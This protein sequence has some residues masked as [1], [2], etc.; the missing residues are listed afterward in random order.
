MYI[1]PLIY[2]M[3]LAAS[4]AFAQLTLPRVDLPRLPGVEVPAVVGD[5]LSTASDTLGARR[6]LDLRQLRID[7][8]IAAH[9]NVIEADPNGAPIVRSQ[10]LAF[11]PSEQA[12]AKARAAG[13]NVVRKHPLEGLDAQLVVLEA[14]SGMSTRR[15]LAR[16]RKLD[17]PGV[18]D[19]NHLFEPGASND[20]RQRYVTAAAPQ[21]DAVL[22]SPRAGAGLIDGG[23]DAS[24]P[25]FR[26]V[27]LQQRGCAKEAVPSAHGTAVASLLVGSAPHF[28]GAAAGT[29]L[30]AYDVYCG[31][32]TGGSAD[33]LLD[34][35]SWMAAERVA[36]INVSLV[37]PPNRA[38]ETVVRLLLARG[39]LIV[40][41]VGNDGPAAPP[42][43]PAAYPGVIGVTGVDSRRRVLIEAGRGAH[44][45]FA[46]PGADIVA[47][48]PG[49]TFAR[50]RGTSFAAPIVAGLLARK[51]QA[52]SPAAA[53]SALAELSREA[54]DLGP[55]GRDTTFGAGLVGESFYKTIGIAEPGRVE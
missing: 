20:A 18:Y 22:N 10:V 29:A 35:L 17:P 15:A 51:L 38:V 5:T 50:V 43:Y 44:V 42:A 28:A 47:A 32:V 3:L 41:A 49:G 4:P 55:R 25:V 7:A 53:Q 8:L 30:A 45:S 27:Q 40:A 52:P 11:A 19:F 36:V 13:F 54:V 34:A 6:L 23:V 9:R 37:G 46:A 33:R 31:E 48:A 14:P 2:L 24:H 1:K 16:L 39:H 21:S 26:N 12:L